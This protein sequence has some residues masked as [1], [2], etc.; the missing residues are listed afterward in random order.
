MIDHFF[1]FKK[2]IIKCSHKIC[3]ICLTHKNHLRL[4]KVKG[5][6]NKK[7]TLSSKWLERLQIRA[8]LFLLKF[9]ECQKIIDKQKD[10]IEELKKQHRVNTKH[11]R[12]KF[13]QT[14]AD[15]E[16]ELSKIPQVKS[17]RWTNN[18][19]YQLLAE[20]DCFY[21][22]GFTRTG[23]V[24]QARI[25]QWPSELIFHTRCFIKHYPTRKLQAIFFGNSETKLINWRDET[26]DVM[27]KKYAKPV[28]INDKSKSEQYWN[29]E[30][31]KKNTPNFVYKLRGL[32]PK[33]QDV[34]VLN[35][36]ST[37]Q[38]TQ[39]VQTSHEI[40]KR[41]TNMHKHRKLFK[42][43][44][45]GCTNGIPLHATYHYGDGH[46][47][48]G[49]IFQASLDVDH[50][51]MCEQVIQDDTVNTKNIS[52]K[53][54][55]IIKETKNLQALIK[56]QD[57]CICDN[58]YRIPDPKVK[59][60][61]ESPAEDDQDGQTTVVASS[62]KRSITA[63]RQTEERVHSMVKRN[64]FCRTELRCDD[65]KRVPKVWNISLGDLVRENK[66]IM[67]DDENSAALT[68]RIL[69]MRYCATNPADVYWTPKKKTKK[70]NKK[71]KKKKKKSETGSDDEEKQEEEQQEDEEEEDEDED[72]DEDENEEKDSDSDSDWMI[73]AI[74]WS[75]ILKWIKT[76]FLKD[77]LR[78][79][80]QFDV[81]NYG[82]KHFENFVGKKYLRRMN[83]NEKNFQLKI[84]KKDHMVMM[85]ENMK[86][87]WKSSN[88][89]D[90][91]LCWREMYL[92]KCSLKKLQD[93]NSDVLIN[94]D[95][96]HWLL[97][98]QSN[99]TQK[100]SEFL[101]EKYKNQQRILDERRKKRMKKRRKLYYGSVNVGK[102]KKADLIYFAKEQSVTINEKMEKTKL[103]D[104]ILKC[105]RDR[106][107]NKKN[108]K[109][110]SNEQEQEEQKEDESSTDYLKKCA[111]CSKNDPQ[112]RC[113]AC[114]LV[115]YCCKDC[116]FE[117]WN[118]EHKK[119]CN[120]LNSKSRKRL[121]SEMEEEQETDSEPPMKEQKVQLD[122]DDD[123][124]NDCRDDANI[125]E[126][127]SYLRNY[128]TEKSWYD[129]DFTLFDSQ[130]SR[131]QLR[132]SCRSGAQLP[133]CCA[134]GITSIWL[135]YF[136]LFSDI[137]EILKQTK[138]DKQIMD[139]FIDLTPYSVYQ[140]GR[141]QKSEHW[142]YC[143]QEKDEG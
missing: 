62:Y 102:M 9:A 138:R 95:E 19:Q 22:T 39:T 81:W 59:A 15:Y 139:N 119:M 47:S 32:D 80:K 42:I 31:I 53:D 45:W 76:S 118:K 114:K 27:E 74:G 141:K 43:H 26:L 121:R 13:N 99:K 60:P 107:L 23:I 92:F 6:K 46:H 131:L 69:D 20:S 87:K 29:R 111:F 123:D 44:F 52:F 12:I 18:V 41:M 133:G 127:L 66:I 136:V 63:I 96:K 124:G 129:L 137:Q 8:M 77:L 2:I 3:N 68:E 4:L 56:M 132:C 130:L 28:L 98:L 113:S 67:K 126:S 134:H 21:L 17:T 34:I 75:N 1:V 54:A 33:K 35:C 40:R 11:Q 55:T 38:Y 101:S 88:R 90:I 128:P 104:Y 64:A 36:D 117:D 143:Q 83:Y 24:K 94:D 50:I 73:V 120:R 85:F 37:Y 10:I 30:K 140:K 112:Y 79:V 109:S 71:K 110:I 58:G 16:K 105:L 78:T 122:D 142:C 72:E 108:K 106:P 93:P 49:K 5:F 82:G 14:F 116:Q 84:Y 86:S 61:A 65:I 89:Y 125:P 25:C 7:H 70:K 100:V 135:I 115:A 91:I 97:W 103:R 51:A 57:H 48:D